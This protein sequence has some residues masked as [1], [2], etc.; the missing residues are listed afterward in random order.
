MRVVVPFY[1]RQVRIFPL[2]LICVVLLYSCKRTTSGDFPVVPPLTYPLSRSAIGYGVVSASYT[3]VVD[4]PELQ[5][6]SQGY[7]RRGSIVRIIERR[8]VATQE[9]SAVWVLVEGNYRG[10]LREAVVDIYDNEA[11]A[12]TAAEF[13]IQ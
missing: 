4:E 10:W 8:F 7:L 1:I 6:E 13:M 5:G 9:D 12:G 2:L 3:Q 11:Q